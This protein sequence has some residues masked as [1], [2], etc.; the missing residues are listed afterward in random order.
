MDKK[1]FTLAEVLITLGVIGVVASMTIPTVIQEHKK[2]VVANKLKKASS[3]L[4]QAHNLS[5]SEYGDEAINREG[6]EPNDAD[7]AFKMFEKYY[8]PYIKFLKVKKG[9][10]GVFGYMADG[11]VFY[12]RKFRGNTSTGWGSTYIFICMNQKACDSINEDVS[13]EN[14]IKTGKEIFTLYTSGIVPQYTFNHYDRDARFNQC[15]NQSNAE[16]CTSLIFEA[17]WQIP[18]D[19]P[20]RL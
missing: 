7:E 16:A 5:I 10:K 12:F 6:F 18:D 15:K 13:T 19:Y 3:S 1:A 11:T 20:I 8:V 4:M 9:E 2:S 17:G 14:G